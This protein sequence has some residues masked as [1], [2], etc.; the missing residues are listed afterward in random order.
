MGSVI[1]GYQQIVDEDGEP[2]PI[3]EVG[4]LLISGP[5][6]VSIYIGQPEES[7][8]AFRDGW[9]HSG[10]LMREI[11]PSVFQFVSRRS[12]M[13][14]VGGIRVFPLEIELVIMQHPEV[15]ACV[16]VRAVD[17]RGGAACHCA[18]GPQLNP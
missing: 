9:Y 4:E 13:L 10:D 14:K 3:G 15:S 7:R 6:V 2:L 1:Q 11:Q 16:V 5:A 18:A 17:P 8:I 12:E